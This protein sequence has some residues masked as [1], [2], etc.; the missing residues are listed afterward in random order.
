MYL[1]KRMMLQIYP[2][3]EYH[4]MMPLPDLLVDVAYFYAE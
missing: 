4:L 1:A 2:Q 3:S